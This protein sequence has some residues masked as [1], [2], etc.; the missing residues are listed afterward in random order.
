MVTISRSIVSQYERFSIYNSPYPAHDS[1]CAIDLYPGTDIA[2]SPVSGTVQTIKSVQCPDKSYATSK[3]Y[4][5]I[6]RCESYIARILHVDPVVDIG[7]TV[8]AGDSLGTLIRSGFFSRW[9]DKHIHLEFRSSTQD[10]HRARGSLQVELDVSV[11]G[12]NWN[13]VGTVTESGSTYILVSLPSTDT[14]SGFVGLAD[15]DGIPLD[16]GLA[17]YDAGG[18]FSSIRGKRSLLGTVVGVADGRDI[19]WYDTSVYVNDHEA[20]GLS[21]FAMQVPYRIKIIFDNGH[22]FN[23]GDEIKTSIDPASN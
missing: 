10:I 19:R 14:K 9:V 1:G 12:I 2:T 8:N 7:E 4:L 13:G 23:I 20:T 15:D 17:H 6:I 3:E 16:G 5:L 11:T 21:L 18:A 22:N